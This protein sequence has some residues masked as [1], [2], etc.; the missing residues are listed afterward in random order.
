MRFIAL[1]LLLALPAFA[2]SSWDQEVRLAAQK[3]HIDPLL[4]K[5]V[6]DRESKGNALATSRVGARGLMQVMPQTARELGIPNAYHGM[7]NLMGACEYLRYLLN[8][9][10]SE[11]PKVL[12][13]YNAGPARVDQYGGIPPFPETQKYVQ[14]VLK[15][16]EK[17]RKT[18]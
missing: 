17:L 7:S 3:F 18:R 14:A 10:N 8:R 1:S 6:M 13:A 5:A 2:T 12:A 15:T 11:L 16:Y 9:Y 4:V